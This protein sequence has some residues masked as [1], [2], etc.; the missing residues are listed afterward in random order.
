MTTYRC[1][2][3]D[4]VFDAPRIARGATVPCPSCATPVTAKYLDF[5]TDDKYTD[6]DFEPPPKRLKV[7]VVKAIGRSLSAPSF[8]AWPLGNMATGLT[9]VKDVANDPLWSNPGASDIRLPFSLLDTSATTLQGLI[10]DFAEANRSPK[11]RAHF[12][13]C[14]DQMLTSSKAADVTEAVGEVATA[15]GVLSHATYRNYGLLWGFDEHSGTGIDQIWWNGN[16]NA[17]HYLIVEAKGPNQ[18]LHVDVFGPAGLNQMEAGWV[19]DRLG[20]MQSGGGTGSALAGRIISQLKKEAFVPTHL[21]GFKGSSKSYYALRT[22]S[23]GVRTATISGL[24]MQ[25]EWRADGMLTGKV[26]HTHDFGL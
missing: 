16:L 2:S 14:T 9:Y 22:T 6:A 15:M 10:I 17:P 26:I 18:D 4:Q 3:C 5:Q 11:V 12:D 24:T 21:A 25:A 8:T 19:C 7:R 13:A 1:R 20:R 23:T